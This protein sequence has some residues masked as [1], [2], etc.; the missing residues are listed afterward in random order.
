MD[1]SSANHVSGAHA[2][3]ASVYAACCLL[4]VL[5]LPVVC[6]YHVD[7]VLIQANMLLTCLYCTLTPHQVLQPRWL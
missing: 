5:V 7:G 6:C 2:A 3:G 4:L 1:D